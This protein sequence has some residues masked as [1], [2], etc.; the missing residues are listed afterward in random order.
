MTQNINQILNQ[1]VPKFS[2][3]LYV[4]IV[5]SVKQVKIN[6]DMS[7]I[8][9]GLVSIEENDRR[10]VHTTSILKKRIQALESIPKIF[11]AQCVRTPLTLGIVINCVVLGV[12]SSTIGGIISALLICKWGW[13]FFQYKQ[14]LVVIDR[15]KE[16]LRVGPPVRI[17]HG[18]LR[19]A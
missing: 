13:N 3:L 10:G 4:P 7:K 17:R 9:R 8:S 14:I 19:E 6:W 11:L 5:G 12:F 15:M 18:N 16:E 2:N 1:P